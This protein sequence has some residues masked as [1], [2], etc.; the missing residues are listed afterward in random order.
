MTAGELAD[1]C[2]DKA[3]NVS[4]KYMWGDYG[5]TI[6]EA[7]IEAKAKQYPTRYSQARIAELKKCCNG[8][9]IGCDCVGLIKWCLWTDRGRHDI[10]YDSKTDKNVTGYKHM[11]TLGDI[12]DIPDI[13]GLLLFMSG[14]VGVYV[15]DGEAVECTLGPWGDGIVRTKVAG[16]G[17]KQYGYLSILDYDVTPSSSIT[18]GDN[19]QFTGSRH[20]TNGDASNGKVARQGPARV[21]DYRPQYKH[22]YHVVHTDNSSNVYGWVNSQDIRK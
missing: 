2:A 21:T 1:F 20:Y 7:T 17:W 15:G 5:R 18:I 11:C 4:S 3:K 9:W 10:V 16:R 12:E 6:T 22:P 13:R 14:H 19:V 8:Y